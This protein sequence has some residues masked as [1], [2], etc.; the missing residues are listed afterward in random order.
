[1]KTKSRQLFIAVEKGQSRNVE[2]LL[3]QGVSV[4]IRDETDG[5]TPLI[6]AAKG[7]N[8]VIQQLLLTYGADPKSKDAAGLSALH[9][10]AENGDVESLKLLLAHGASMDAKDSSG[11]TPLHYSV[12][13][14]RVSTTDLL[15]FCGADAKLMNKRNVAPAKVGR[16]Q[17]IR[18][19]LEDSEKIVDG[20]RN[21]D[22]HFESVE[23]I[24][25]KKIVLPT[26][27]LEIDTPETFS[28]KN[29][30]FL[31]RRVRPEYCSNRRILPT[32]KELL[33]SDTFEYRTSSTHFNGIVQMGVPLYAYPEPYEDIYLK[34][35]ADVEYGPINRYT[36]I[37]RNERSKGKLKWMCCVELDVTKVNSFVLVTRPRVEY[38]NVGENGETFY[39]DVDKFLQI[40]VRPNTF[41]SGKIS[42]EVIPSPVYNQDTYKNVLSIGH[43]YDMNHSYHV[44][45]FHKDGVGFTMPIPNDFEG[46]GE[47][48][49]LGANLNSDFDYE[50]DEDRETILSKWEI[51]N[52]NLNPK[53]GKV[54]CALS[55]FSI[56]VP[57]ERRAPILEEE[58]KLNADSLLRRSMRRQKFLNFFIMTKPDK[59][60][61][62]AVIECAPP[63]KVTDRM[64]YW[65][66]LGY[67]Q[68]K[69]E[70]SIT[71]DIETKK[72]EEYEIVFERNIMK[73]YG[74]KSIDLQYHPKRDNFKP[75]Q[76][77][78]IDRDKDGRGVILVYR[79]VN[80]VRDDNETTI[81]PVVLYDS[82]VVD[83]PRIDDS[84]FQ[85]FLRNSLLKRI[86]DKLGSPAW[87][88]VCILLGLSFQTID[89]YRLKPSTPRQTLEHKIFKIL[90]EWRER[91]KNRED[92]G[93]PDL[94]LALHR[95]NRPDL[96]NELISELRNWLDEKE[97]EKDAFIEW[98]EENMH[99]L[100]RQK[101]INEEEAVPMSDSFLVLFTRNNEHM[102]CHSLG[103]SMDLYESQVNDVI[104]DSTIPD[105]IMKLV[106]VLVMARDKIGDDTKSFTVLADALE[107]CQLM[108]A[109]EWLMNSATKWCE[110]KSEKDTKFR[111]DIK[112]ALKEL[113]GEKIDD[114]DMDDDLKE[115]FEK[116]D[117]TK[118][119]TEEN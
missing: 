112:R 115:E 26:I 104:E 64:N 15:V 103:L 114:S 107:T 72:D 84:E 71:P 48:C 39:S 36:G 19:L 6:R 111:K 91:C 96:E 118:D 21:N 93:V 113:N 40:Q 76:L 63:Q 42:L 83:T 95:V 102:N 56:Y 38:F 29:L 31:C 60:L 73:A 18:S 5:S 9:Y 77:E 52:M 1:M 25:G 90:L 85:G 41:E 98:A 70:I 51:I 65:R 58:T 10:I 55:H 44:G 22:I 74:S 100:G 68:N 75:F 20:I 28:A 117:F 59:G 46:D 57:V 53:G 86:A 67:L 89:E 23:L 47:L 7:R 54:S 97:G 106:K 66:S 50:K 119:E 105:H 24:A 61:H 116:G 12:D 87:I 4:N 30:S 92:R 81:L 80:G 45:N 16:H 94:V 110:R 82:L 8:Y 3:D 32:K 99:G 2:V 43:F 62:Q 79:K 35:D 11:C 101:E 33:I 37:Y 34:T 78:V 13:R 14:S 109:R 108:S 17:K 88:Q 69:E 49:I 27:D